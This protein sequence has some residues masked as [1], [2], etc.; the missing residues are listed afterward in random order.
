MV[1]TREEL[2]EQSVRQLLGAV[3]AQRELLACYR[4][5]RRPSERL[6]GQLERI[7]PAIEAARALLVHQFER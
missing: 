6:H 2:L 5:D 1:A 3:Q 7:D 4:V